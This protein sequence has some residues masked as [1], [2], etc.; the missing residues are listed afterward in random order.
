VLN[1]EEVSSCNIFVVKG[2]TIK[3][4]PLSGTIL[5]GV[6]RRS[7]IELARIRGYT[8]EETPVSVSEAME[9][10]EIFT[11]GTGEDTEHAPL[12][13]PTN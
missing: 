11:T 2:K 12:I 5:P 9:A 3:T 1:L 13:D 4:P 6:T 10:D 7:I 8:V